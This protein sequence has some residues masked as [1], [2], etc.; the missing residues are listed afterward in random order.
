MAEDWD[1]IV[2][3][4]APAVVRATM[5]VLGNVADAEDTAQEVF[6]EAFQSRHNTTVLD[7][8]PYLRKIAVCRAIDRLRR[9]RKSHSLEN[10]PAAL[11][12]G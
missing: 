10:A 2:R 3:E 7:W 6:L 1:T 9:R 11:A 5:R 12:G 4:H 8:S